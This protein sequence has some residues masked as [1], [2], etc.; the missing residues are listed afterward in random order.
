MPNKIE[1]TPEALKYLDALIAEG[2]CLLTE[3]AAIDYEAMPVDET[4]RAAAMAEKRPPKRFRE[5]DYPAAVPIRPERFGAWY[6]SSQALLSTVCGKEHPWA[7]SFEKVCYGA[8]RGCVSSGLGLLRA[9][10]MAWPSGF[11]WG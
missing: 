11:V 3:D 5:S 7:T 4:D 8:V 2:H 1:A 6:G 10:R 9:F